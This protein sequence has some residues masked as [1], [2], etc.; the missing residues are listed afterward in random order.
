[1]VCFRADE[2]VWT[3]AGTEGVAEGIGA[4][5][6]KF[7]CSVR[8]IFL[9]GAD[10]GLLTAPPKGGGASPREDREVII[11]RPVRLKD[12]ESVTSQ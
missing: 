4:R 1:M 10:R 9:H 5:R 7:S 2:A 12:A 3:E 8:E 6:R 11:F